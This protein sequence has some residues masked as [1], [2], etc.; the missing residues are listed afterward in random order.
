MQS[1]GSFI[2]LFLLGIVENDNDED[3]SN[4][5]S[6]SFCKQ[7]LVEEERPQST[8]DSDQSSTMSSNV[9]SMILSASEFFSSQSQCAINNTS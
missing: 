4:R 3:N 2:K 8:D 9:N 5:L 7:L 1:V 6:V